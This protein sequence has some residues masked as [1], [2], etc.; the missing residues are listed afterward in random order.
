[1]VLP[2]EEVERVCGVSGVRMYPTPFVDEGATACN[3]KVAVP[4]NLSGL[5]FI[6]SRFSDAAT[7]RSGQGVASE[8][9]VA[10]ERR[11]VPGLGDAATRYVRDS[12]AGRTSTRVLAVAAG[13]D[14]IEMKSTVMPDEPDAE[15]CSLDQLETL[16]RG[17]VERLRP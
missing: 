10:T 12:E 13:L 16:A 17:V 9:E 4:G 2:L 1:M 15:V 7:A 14:L 5:V 3:R 6:V 8:S 11:D